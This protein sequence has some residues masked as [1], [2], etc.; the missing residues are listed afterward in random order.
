MLLTEEH[1]SE[2]ENKMSEEICLENKKSVPANFQLL[3]LVL[4][5]QT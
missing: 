5:T 2:E 4:I 1:V 3:R